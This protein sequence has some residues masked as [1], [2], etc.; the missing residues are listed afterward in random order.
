MAKTI[1]YAT[2]TIDTQHHHNRKYSLDIYSFVLV[3]VLVP[4]SLQ[5][6]MVIM[7]SVE[8]EE[9]K[10]KKEEKRKKNKQRFKVNMFLG[11]EG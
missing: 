8:E 9:K 10:K 4:P 1:P 11:H 5:F 6:I 7:D 3:D 2:L